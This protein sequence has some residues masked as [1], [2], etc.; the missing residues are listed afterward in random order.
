MKNK[1][2]LVTWWTWFIWSHTVVE[3]QQA[4]YA[5]VILD[6]LS[7]SDIK[8]LDAIESI[9][10]TRPDF[11]E[12]DLLDKAGMQHI[13]EKYDVWAV[14]HFAGLKAVGVSCAEPF[15][16]WQT[17]I[18][19]IMHLLELMDAHDVRRLVFSSSATV[20]D[21]SYEESPFD[22]TM[23]TGHT[24]NPY[25]TTKHIIEQ[26]LEDMVQRKG[27]S[28]TSLRYFNPIWAHQ[29]WTLWEDPTDIPNNLFPIILDV[30]EWKRETLQ[31]FG[32]DYDTVDWSG[33]R[34]YIH[35]VDLAKA[36][37]LA[38]EKQQQDSYSVYNVWTWRW[39][40]VLEM[41]ALVEKV[42][43]KKIQRAYAPRRAGD[44]ATS[45]A[46]CDRIGQDLWWSEQLTIDDAVQHG[47][48][49]RDNHRQ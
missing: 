36:H 38:L 41:I 43:W 33:V 48:G 30:L 13:F 17:N 23:R 42:S 8:V 26:L 37:V 2:V 10:W 47:I 4:G 3:L 45:V 27:M 44:I 1:Y 29:S 20:Y 46:A 11:V 7:N 12:C 5:V 49:F 35:V 16:Y 9:T 24:T 15:S 31:V 21:A 40:S 14:L 6:N 32:N 18:V 25:G 39:T 19:W 34:D 28:I 22:E